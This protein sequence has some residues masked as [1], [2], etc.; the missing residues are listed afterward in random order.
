MKVAIDS[1]NEFLT[2]GKTI[3]KG[4]YVS[5]LINKD[6]L[7]CNIII[8]YAKCEFLKGLYIDIDDAVEV[9]V[10]GNN[11]LSFLKVTV[12]SDMLQYYLKLLDVCTLEK[13][14]FYTYLLMK[15]QL[16][17]NDTIVFDNGRRGKILAFD[18]SPIGQIMYKI[19]KKDGSLG[20]RNFTLYG[21]Y[22]YTCKD[23][24]FINYD[25]LN[26]R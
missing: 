25:Y 1:I 26:L 13:D 15:N 14:V 24:K 9:F 12:P 6:N 23:R 22:K 10:E 16:K 17:I 20:V 3:N 11:L 4:D 2:S 5:I 8:Q 18:T 21:N 19:I 7:K